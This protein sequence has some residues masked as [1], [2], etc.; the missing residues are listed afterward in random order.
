MK[1]T[2][3]HQSKGKSL[4]ALIAQKL[5]PQRKPKLLSMSKLKKKADNV[6][7]H[8]IRDRDNHT[9]FT[10]N[11]ILSTNESQNG[12]FISRTHTAT[13]YLEKNCNCQC[14]GCNIFKKG[15]YPIYALRL[16]QLYGNDILQELYD[17]SK[18]TIKCDRI[19]LNNIIN[20]YK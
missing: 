18:T 14:V 2:N 20:K 7:S 17:L 5:K 8:W 12:H 11:K 4:K 10:C 19:F 9:C 16:Q 6:F 3:T 13:R 1:K 15:N